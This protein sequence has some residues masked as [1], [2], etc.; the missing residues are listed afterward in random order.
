MFS[1]AALTQTVL[2]LPWGENSVSW[3]LYLK[4]ATR[5]DTINATPLFGQGIWDPDLHH[6]KTLVVLLA[7][8]VVIL[9]YQVIRQWVTRVSSGR[10]FRS[11]CF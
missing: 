6:H 10:S 1:A 8:F 3:Y 11:S 7:I 5:A 4:R 2:L 9:A